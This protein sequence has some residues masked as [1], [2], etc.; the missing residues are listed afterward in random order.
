MKPTIAQAATASQ[1]KAQGFAI[2]EQD[3]KIIRM[4]R[5]NDYRIVQQDGTQKRAYGAK[6]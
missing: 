6:R 3:C 4:A 1:L 5:G 2:L